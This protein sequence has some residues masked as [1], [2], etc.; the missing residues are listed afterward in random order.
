MDDRLDL[1]T[2]AV[3]YFSAFSNRDLEELS[4]IY[5][6]N[7]TLRDW[8]IEV[9]GKNAVLEANQNIFNAVNSLKIVP[10]NMYRDG[11]T[12][13]SEIEIIIND[14]DILK[15]VDV[16]DFDGVGKI[17]NIRAYKG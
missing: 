7:V 10:L 6:D 3:Q 1:K 4:A 17:L 8:D 13:A 5:A 11:S 14:R 16:I 9:S 15:V 12:L 2:L